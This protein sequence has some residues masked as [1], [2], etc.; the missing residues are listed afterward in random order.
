MSAGIVIFAVYAVL[1]R[2]VSLV[3]STRNEMRL[4]REGAIEYGRGGTIF[5]TSVSVLYAAGAIAEGVVRRVQLDAIAVWGIAIH[6]FS[7][8]V[9]FSVIYE[10]RDVWTIKILIAR[11]HRLVTGWLFRTFKHPNYFLNLIPEYIGLTLVFTAWITAAVLFPLLVL[12]IGVRIVQEEQAM[13]QA[14]TGYRGVLPPP[15][16]E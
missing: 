2:G 15:S 16:G 13:R 12:A 7:M 11:Q 6:A 1:L 8:V 14:F 4:K 10:L 5:L 3:I 9:L